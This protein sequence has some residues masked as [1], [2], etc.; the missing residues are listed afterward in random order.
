MMFARLRKFLSAFLLNGKSLFVKSAPTIHFL[1]HSFEAV[2]NHVQIPDGDGL[3]RQGAKRSLLIRRHLVQLI[4]HGL[5]RLFR[6]RSGAIGRHSMPCDLFRR[7]LFTQ[8]PQVTQA[9]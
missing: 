3:P 8:A 9:R 2:L 1:G 4:G 6:L 7:P 5:G